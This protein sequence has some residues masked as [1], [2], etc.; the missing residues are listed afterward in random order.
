MCVS[1]KKGFLHPPGSWW[2]V[3]PSQAPTW[4]VFSILLKCLVFNFGRLNRPNGW[5]RMLDTM[6]LS[7]LLPQMVFMGNVLSF[8]DLPL[9]SRCSRRSLSAASLIIHKQKPENRNRVCE[10][11]AFVR[12]RC[13]QSALRGENGEKLMW[14]KLGVVVRRRLM[15][16]SFNIR[17]LGTNDFTQLHR[18]EIK[19]PA[20]CT[21][22]M[23]Y[24]WLHYTKIR[25]FVLWIVATWSK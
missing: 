5:I 14:W 11:R 16:V 6:I 10:E 2:S 8:I 9:F 3:C 25:I 24:Q 13:R 15:C 22:H 4:V 1:K 23:N 18:R 19:T 17:V 12:Q 20:C 7:T 21:S